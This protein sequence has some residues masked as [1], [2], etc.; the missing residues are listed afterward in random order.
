MQMLLE[1]AHIDF[2]CCE[3]I[4]QIKNKPDSSKGLNMNFMDSLS[5]GE[6]YKLSVGFM[7]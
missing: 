3:N 7:V 5:I 6:L 2:R 4:N 1:I